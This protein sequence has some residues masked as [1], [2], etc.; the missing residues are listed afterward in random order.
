MITCFK[1]EIAKE[2]ERLLKKQKIVTYNLKTILIPLLFMPQHPVTYT[3]FFLPQHAIP[4]TL[5]FTLSVTGMG[6]I[7]IP[8]STG[9]G[10]TFTQLPIK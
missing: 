9:C 4:F 3:S 6:S 7:G 8:I 1:N 2:Q 10:L 5:F